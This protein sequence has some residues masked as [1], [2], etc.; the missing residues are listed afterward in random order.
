MNKPTTF[1]GKVVGVPKQF[2]TKNGPGIELSF[3]LEKSQENSPTTEIKVVGYNG[4]ATKL[5]SIKEGDRLIISVE[6]RNKKDATKSVFFLLTSF[7]L[8]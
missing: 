8:P 2:D 6:P 7:K 5:K 1:H 3:D 4:M